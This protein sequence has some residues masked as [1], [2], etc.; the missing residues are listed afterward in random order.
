M[1]TGSGC[2]MNGSLEVAERFENAIESAGATDSIRLVRTGC[3]GLCERGPVVVVGPD[4][5]FYPSLSTPR[6]PR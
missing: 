2:V 3:H 6:R 1:C 5:I 4:G